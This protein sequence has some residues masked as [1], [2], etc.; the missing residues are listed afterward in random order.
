MTKQNWPTRLDWLLRRMDSSFS[1]LGLRLTRRDF[2]IRHVPE[3]QKLIVRD[4]APY[5]ATDGPALIGLL[6]AIA[7]LEL[8]GIPGAIV[9]CGVYR[10]GS[11]MAA[12]SCLLHHA[13]P[14]TRNLALRH[15]RRDDGTGLLRHPHSRRACRSN[16]L[17][18]RADASRG[19]A[20]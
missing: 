8:N 10:G 11:I 6:D 14:P 18:K 17:R 15:L 16:R 5:T 20:E 4:V 2:D 13:P 12:A 9:E 3:W 19:A 7:Y 1:M